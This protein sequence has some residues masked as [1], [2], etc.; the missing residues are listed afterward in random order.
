MEE[1]KNQFAVENVASKVRLVYIANL[2]EI[3]VELLY[4][5]VK[6]AFLLSASDQ[7]S[8]LLP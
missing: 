8:A 7:L 6:F 2:A 5:G 3:L 4:V 1:L